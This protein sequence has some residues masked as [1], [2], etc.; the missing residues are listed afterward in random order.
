MLILINSAEKLMEI[1]VYDIRK[2]TMEMNG[3][4]GDFTVMLS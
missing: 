2:L 3:W 1:T 4:T